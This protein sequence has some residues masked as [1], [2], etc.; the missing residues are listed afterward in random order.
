MTAW[1]LSGHPEVEAPDLFSVRKTTAMGMAVANL[2]RTPDNTYDIPL[3]Q[4]FERTHTLATSSAAASH[5]VAAEST[6]GWN[7]TSSQYENA[8]TFVKLERNHPILVPGM[9]VWSS[10][11]DFDLLGLIVDGKIEG[12]FSDKRPS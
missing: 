6:F 12:S 10:N 4:L 1:P 2:S 5:A 7:A 8:S 3:F 9:E 11:L